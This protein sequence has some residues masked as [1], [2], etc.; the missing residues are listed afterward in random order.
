VDFFKRNGTN[1]VTILLF[2]AIY[3]ISDIVLANMAYPFYI[4]M[5]FTKSEIANIGK[6]Y[7]VVM[8]ILGAV[9]GGS[10]VLRYGVMRILLLGAILVSLT[11]LLFVQLAVAGH[12]LTWLTIVI[13]R[14]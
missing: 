13:C 6:L 2:I 10:L 1:A 3:R 8:T 9:I 5:S 11:N 14:A 12:D 4:D 7:G